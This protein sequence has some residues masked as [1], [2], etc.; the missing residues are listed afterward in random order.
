MKL[1]IRAKIIGVCGVL[2]A[3]LAV[4]A[5]MGI[6]ELKSSNDRLHQVAANG[7]AAQLS[8][9][10]RAGIAKTTRAERDLLLA[11]S[12]PQRTA[13]VEEI[14]EFLRER[15]DRRKEL[16]ELGDPAITGKLG[17]LDQVIHDYDEVHKQV[18]TLKLKASNA[19]A[20]ELL[21]GEGKKQ[22][23]Q[24]VASLRA[25][26]GEL[27]KRPASPE[28]TA[29]RQTV[30]Q[31]QLE[32]LGHEIEEQWVILEPEDAAMDAALKRAVDHVERL[33]KAVAAAS[34]AATTP[35]EKR[36]ATELETHLVAFEDVHSKARALCRENSD[37]AATLLAQ[38]KGHA[39]I[40]KAGKL[41]DDI[42]AL[43]IAAVKAAQAASEAAYAASRTLLLGALVFALALGIVLAI[44]IS[45]YIAGA[46]AAATQLARTVASGDLTRT[47][48]VTN[49][50]EIGSVVTALNEM[51]ESLR[52]VA[53][54]VTS[55]ATNVATGSNEMS[56][57]ASQVAQGASEQ[58]AAT[59]ETTAAME[60]MAASVQ[61]NADNAQQ[62]DRLASKASTDAQT[63]GRVV[64]ETLSAMKN[65]AERIGIIE[66]I[67]R[68]TDLLALNAAVEAARAGEH[69][70]G[71]AVVA[72]EVRKLA[73]RSATAA[74]EIS[75]LSRSGVALAE[76]AGTMLTQLVP[77]IRKTAELVQEVSAASREQNTGIEQSNKALQDLDRVTQQNA[78]AAEQ[79]AATANE[80]SGQAQQLQSA[81][82]FFKL[83]DGGRGPRAG[84]ARPA[85]PA[86]RSASK[87]ARVNGRPRAGQTIA[88]RASVRPTAPPPPNGQALA[89]RGSERGIELDLGAAP[90]DADDAMFERY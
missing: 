42:V 85:T 16:R 7:S 17:E 78:A 32:V 71:F 81:V 55:A 9:Q 74:A 46:L 49:D 15:D 51:V 66:E 79:M 63:S 18:R 3:A 57:T 34:R 30:W 67:A 28:T 45:R 83:D 26:D 73:E 33:T 65:I 64:G 38:T 39:L 72:S 56:S 36:L 29:V 89:T 13:A 61:Q 80:L 60:E 41:S 20:A 23:E 40:D 19:A 24:L 84:S 58:G 27:A 47:V 43:E 87:P 59:E 86:A 53:R 6:W 37:G 90:S 68:K 69:G 4:T 35:D 50:D 48:E 5:G 54:D 10:V 52:S 2:L 88:A 31:A 14:D 70:R 1:T 8:A 12:A 44:V 11:T 77:D 25:L 82:A 22:N 21:E 62:T 75:Q 76:N